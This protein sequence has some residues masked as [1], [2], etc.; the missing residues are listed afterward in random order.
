MEEGDIGDVCSWSNVRGEVDASGQLLATWAKRDGGGFGRRVSVRRR[1]ERPEAR[2]WRATLLAFEEIAWHCDCGERI[3][4][5]GSVGRC[6]TA[7]DERN[8]KH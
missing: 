5:L 3:R 8:L 4:I 1:C 2:D 6:F 7:I